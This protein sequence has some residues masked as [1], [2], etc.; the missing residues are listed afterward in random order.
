MQSLVLPG[1]TSLLSTPFGRHSEPEDG[2]AKFRSKFSPN[3][4]EHQGYPSPP[5]SESHSPSRRPAQSVESARLS[6]P[7]LAGTSQRQDSL[8]QPPTLPSVYDPRSTSAAHALPLQRA[9]YPGEPQHRG[10]GLHYPPGRP[11]EHQPY[12][13]AIP[14]NYGYGYQNPGLPPYAG[15]QHPGPMVQQGAMIAPPPARPTKPA[16]RTKAHVAEFTRSEDGRPPP[17]QLV[18]APPTSEPHAH[19]PTY[20]LSQ[21]YRAF[22]PQRVLESTT[23]QKEPHSAASAPRDT[24]G[25]Y[26]G[27]QAP[28]FGAG[29][30]MA[31]QKLPVVY[32]N[33][34]LVIQKA[35]QAFADLVSFL[36][37]IRGKHL[38]DLLEAQ[39]NE[40]MQRLRNELRDER[41]EREPTY[42]A[43]ITPIGQDPMRAVMDTVADHDIDHFTQGYTN[44]YSNRK[45]YSTDDV[46]A[47][48][49]SRHAVHAASR[50]TNIDEQ[51]CTELPLFQL[52][53]NPNI[54]SY[55]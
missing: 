50:S 10:Q 53:V 33:L 32:L 37:D 11:L 35:N 23:H 55:V 7:P 2:L 43:P 42:M 9:P 21:P 6:Y 31:Y 28:P 20:P 18:G 39:Q 15:V 44:S 19:Q 46:C 3:R 5:M 4:L 26:S 22:E 1:P 45:A 34:D 12:S 51:F 13:H 30:N 54:S 47:V 48:N 29:P 38:G 8:T 17:T 40:S 14:H 36:G 41:D 27:V 25:E 24:A 52:L 49:G 16:R